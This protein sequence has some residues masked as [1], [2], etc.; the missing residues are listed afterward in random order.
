MDYYKIASERDQT[1]SAI[2]AK[3]AGREISVTEKQHTYKGKHYTTRHVTDGDRNPLVE[4]MNQHAKA[5]GLKLGVTALLNETPRQCAW[6]EVCAP[7]EKDVD[8]K[9]RIGKKFTGNNFVDLKP[10]MP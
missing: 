4:E 10:F 2:F 6:P 7:V 1:L 8:G 5:A 9:Y 3:F